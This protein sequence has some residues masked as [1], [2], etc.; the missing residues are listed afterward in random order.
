VKTVIFNAD[1]FGASAGTN[2]AVIRAHREGVLTSAS[3]MV[4]EPGAEE[5]AELASD[6]PS[7]AVGLHLALSDGRAALTRTEIPHLVDAGGRFRADPARA[8]M[9]YFFRRGPRRELALEIAAQFRRFAAT[10]LPWSHV[11]GHQ[12]LH[13]HPVIWDNL[14]RQCVAHDVRRIRIPYEEFRPASANGR[15]GKRIEWLFFRALRRRCLRSL[16]GKDFTVAERVYGHL[17]TGR[18]SSDYVVNLLGRLGGRT[19]EI[20]FHPGTPH[21]KRLPGGPPGMDVDFDALLSPK[22]RA[23]LNELGL[24]LTNYPGIDRD[25]HPAE[26]SASNSAVHP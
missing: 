23:R 21:A 15:T 26:L 6:T 9:A 24:R 18:M 14:V 11:D 4:N 3:L 19:N 7:L 25:N 13:L 10:G 20:Y 8:G 17:E 5:A 22:V 16:T 12:H 2:A 1:D